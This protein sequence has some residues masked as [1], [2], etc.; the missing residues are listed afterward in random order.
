LDLASPAVADP[1]ALAADLLDPPGG[2]VEQYFDDPAGFIRDCIRHKENE[3]PTDYQLENAGLLVEHGRLCVRGPHG[4]GKTTCAAWLILWFALTRDARG[5]DWKIIT[6]ASAWRQLEKYLWPEVRKWSMRLRWGVIGRH[7]FRQDEMMRL[8]LRLNHGEALAVACEDPATIEGAHADSLLYVYDEAKTIPAETFDA[9]EGAFS[10]AG[11]ETGQEAFAIASSTP[12]EPVGRFYDIQARKPGTEDWTAVHVTKAMVKAAGRMGQK[13][14]DARAKQWGKDSAVFQNRVEGEF[15]TNEADGVIPLAWV[16]AAVARWHEHDRPKK[17]ELT[18]I[19]MDVAEE[20]GDQTTL[21][22]R[23]GLRIDEIRRVPRGDVME[24]TGHAVI[25]LQGAE[26]KPPVIVDAIGIGAGIPPRLREQGYAAVAFKASEKTEMRDRSGE[27]QFRDCKAAAWWRARD[28]LDPANGHDVQ[29]PPD[30]QLLADLIAPRWKVGS[31]GK[32]EIESKDDL[33]KRIG[34]SPDVGEAVIHALWRGAGGTV[35]A[36][37][38][39]RRRSWQEPLRARAHH[40]ML[41][42]FGR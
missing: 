9:S 37:I 20:G 25:A 7:P 42:G 22:L 12:G 35:G 8:G 41:S 2:G 16:E 17:T 18:C 10:G 6:T 40:N 29:L 39:L 3:G 38:L 30:E 33:R 36:P 15:A 21:A 34:R 1:F 32:V 13:W 26:G 23:Y 28:L 5:V 19:G 4:L 11:E 27:L 24:A 14:A 31:S